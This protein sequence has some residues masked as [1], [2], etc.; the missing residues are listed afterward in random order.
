MIHIECVTPT[1]TH[2]IYLPVLEIIKSQIHVYCMYLTVTVLSTHLHHHI[3]R[4]CVSSL[5]NIQVFSVD[6]VL[7]ITSST[8]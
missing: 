7:M 6:F 4:A 8:L 1:H 2:Y 5:F 3:T